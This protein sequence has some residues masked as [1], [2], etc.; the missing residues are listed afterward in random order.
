M[1]LTR[2]PSDPVTPTVR[3][4]LRTTLPLLLLAPACAGTPRTVEIRARDYAFA[5]PATLPPGP[6]TFRFINDGKVLH[7]V[8]LF[9][10]RKGTSTEVAQRYLSSGT[11]P[12]SAIEGSG[13]V[14]IT[15]A[16]T[17]A[18]EAVTITLAH[19]DVYGLQC[20]FH[21]ADSLPPHSKLGMWKV[22]QVN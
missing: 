11:I 17:S 1:R 21:D 8:Q 18:H 2:H 5:A 13:A 14:L 12:D 16:G 19:G 3:G 6:T 20:E 9:Q 7:E 10:F 4:P 15:P 22:M